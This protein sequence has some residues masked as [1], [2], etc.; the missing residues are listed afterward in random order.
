MNWDSLYKWLE[1][2]QEDRYEQPTWT[3][4]YKCARAILVHGAKIV[5]FV[6]KIYNL[7]VGCRSLLFERKYKHTQVGQMIE[8]SELVSGSQK[9][10]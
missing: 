7:D 1:R 5:L 10:I 4:R 8:P 9:V 2:E 6:H 3:L